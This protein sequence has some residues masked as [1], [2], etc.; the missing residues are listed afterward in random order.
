[1]MI[2]AEMPWDALDFQLFMGLRR[3]VPRA[4]RYIL[5]M[6]GQNVSDFVP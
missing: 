6:S 3:R 2:S 1:M 5:R 4:P